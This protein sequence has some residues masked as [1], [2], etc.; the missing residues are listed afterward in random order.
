MLDTATQADSWL[1]ATL[2]PAGIIDRD[3]TDRLRDVLGAL[4]ASASLVVVDL[5]AA[6]LRSPA[7][8]AVIDDAAHGLERRGGCLLCVGADD[9]A[10]RAL[11]TAGGHAVVL[12]GAAA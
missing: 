3:D 8:A 5:E 1:T 2:R 6:A 4:A 11:A 7:A 12:D 9:G 10:R